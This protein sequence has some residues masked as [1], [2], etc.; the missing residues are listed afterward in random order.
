MSFNNLVEAHVLRALRSVHG[1]RMTSV[2]S[3]LAYAEKQLGISRLLLHDKLL[4]SG[5]DLFLQELDHLI[6]LSRSGQFALRKLLEDCLRR[7]QRD[8]QRL[9]FRLYPVLPRE[10]A[11]AKAISINPRVSFGRP[12]LAGS[13]VSTRAL[14]DR[15]D[16]GEDIAVVAHD[17]GLDESQIHDAVLYETAA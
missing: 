2:R 7:V 10:S 9:P 8:D 1:A 15:I 17:Y 13:G 14:V 5:G 6:N 3:A 12:V 4:T 11:N 16:A